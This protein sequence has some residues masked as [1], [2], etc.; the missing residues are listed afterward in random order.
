QYVYNLNPETLRFSNGT[1]APDI[2]RPFLLYPGDY[3]FTVTCGTD[4][5]TDTITRNLTIRRLTFHIPQDRLT[6]L[7]AGNR[8]WATMNVSALE[9]A[10]R[11]PND[12]AAYV[13]GVRRSLYID[14]NL[15]RQQFSP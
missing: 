3:T 4:T 1:L 9:P 11:N 13:E 10:A 5:A 12:I 6:E 15:S 14:F 8:S 2:L 7:Y